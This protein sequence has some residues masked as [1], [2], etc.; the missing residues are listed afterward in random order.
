MLS[1]AIKIPAYRFI[2]SAPVIKL[3]S[4]ELLSEQAGREGQTRSYLTAIAQFPQ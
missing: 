1:E 2:E 4:G 3:P